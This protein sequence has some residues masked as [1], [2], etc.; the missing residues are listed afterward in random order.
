MKLDGIE[1]KGETANTKERFLLPGGTPIEKG[2]VSAQRITISGIV[3]GKALINFRINWYC[4]LDIDAD[5]DLRRSGWRLLLEGETP[6]D[7]SI[8]FPLPAEQ[9]SPAM[10]AITAYRV[11]NAVPYVCAAEPGIR[12]TIELPTIAPKM[13]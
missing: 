12:T 7:M 6:I 1:V 2:T 4:N 13:A 9:V 5:W 10:A 11:I 3:D 8:T